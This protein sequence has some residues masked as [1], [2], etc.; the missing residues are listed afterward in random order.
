VS[1]TQQPS[2]Y[3][4]SVGVRWVSVIVCGATQEALVSAALV[5]VGFLL[6]SVRVA[7]GAVSAC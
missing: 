2:I 1:Y 5:S 3:R 6:V 4:V 7:T